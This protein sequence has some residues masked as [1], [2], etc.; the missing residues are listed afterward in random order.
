MRVCFGE[1]ELWP[2]ISIKPE[3]TYNTSYEIPDELIAAYR[4][5]CKEFFKQRIL[6]IEAFNKQGA[7]ISA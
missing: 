2:D 1:D 7:D 3:N 5:A 6:L 4:A